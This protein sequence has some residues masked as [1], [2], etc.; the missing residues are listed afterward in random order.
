MGAT[1][2]PIGKASGRYC[3]DEG[4]IMDLHLQGKSAKEIA[5]I[6]SLPETW[7][8]RT[9]KNNLSTWRIENESD[10]T[11][12]VEFYTVCRSLKRKL[13]R[14]ECLKSSKSSI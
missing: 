12:C 14:R 2:R 7:V 4:R 11:L 1:G 13:R 6:L 5:A 3:V 9:I 8:A 10:A